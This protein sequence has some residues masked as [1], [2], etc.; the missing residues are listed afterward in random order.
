MVCH[1]WWSTNVAPAFLQAASELLPLSTVRAL[2]FCMPLFG[3]KGDG[4]VAKS[5]LDDY[6][7]P[8]DDESECG[9][10]YPILVSITN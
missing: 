1:E 8:L 6:Q 4:L 9:T 7:Q 2:C 10:N 3:D 5:M